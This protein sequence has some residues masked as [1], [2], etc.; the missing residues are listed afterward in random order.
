MA[1]Q[2]WVEI[3]A[4]RAALAPVSLSD[5]HAILLPSGR[6]DDIAGDHEDAMLMR[7]TA[8]LLGSF[9]IAATIVSLPTHGSLPSCDA[10][11]LLKERFNAAES[12]IIAV[13]PELRVAVI[14]HS[15]GGT[16][17]L[18]LA[19]ASH[20]RDRI[21]SLTLLGTVIESP[22][23]ISTSITDIG[24]I[25]GARDHITYVSDE[26]ETKVQLIPA[27]QFGPESAKRLILARKQSMRVTIL[28][29]VGHSMRLWRPLSTQGYSPE[30]IFEALG[31]LAREWVETSSH[32]GGYR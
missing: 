20:C 10:E 26:T 24:L 14:G 16:T 1:S 4:Y 25:Y 30:P 19:N 12:C 32:A 27:S 7:Q 23:T 3:D 9:G 28:D 17:A 29:G 31:S 13:A 8:D 5:L 18:M 15:L 11:T 22:M 21:S 6:V 2:S